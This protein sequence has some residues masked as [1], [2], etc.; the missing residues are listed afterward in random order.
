MYKFQISVAVATEILILIANQMT[1]Y[2]QFVVFCF[3]H[4][5]LTLMALELCL[6]LFHHENIPI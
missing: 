2:D 4:E 6:K 3:C 5:F 1:V